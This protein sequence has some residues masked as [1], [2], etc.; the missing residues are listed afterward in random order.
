MDIIKFI[1]EGT[2]VPNPNYKK[3]AKKGLSA[4]PRLHS[5]N[6]EDVKDPTDA[7]ARV[8]SEQTYGLTYLRDEANKFSKNRAYIN[9][10]SSQEELEYERA[11]NQPLMTQFGHMLGQ[12][13]GNEI[14]LGTVRGFSD[15]FD[16]AVNA[17]SDENDYTN[18]VSRTI[19]DWQSYVRDELLPIYQKQNDE[20]FH[21]ND[22]GW[23]MNGL[24]SAATTVSLMVPGMAVSKGAGLIGKIG[25]IGGK[26]GKL[27]RKGVRVLSKGKNTGRIY[28]SL[29]G[30][31]KIGTMAFVSRTAENYQEAREVYKN[32]YN[33]SLSELASMSSEERNDLYSRNPEF[34]GLSD[35]EIAE[36][37]ASVSSGHTFRNDYWMLLM[38]IP[39]FKALSSIWKGA[40]VASKATTR[41]L[42][43]ANRE[44]IARLTGKSAAEVAAEETAKRTAKGSIL[45]RIGQVLKDLCSVKVLKKV[46]K[47]FKLKK[48]KKLVIFILILN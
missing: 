34:Q 37:I 10:I 46:S 20:G 12:A 1:K 5:D 38:D 48:E 33:K 15:L 28:H 17:F 3:G 8:I 11:K 21:I 22:F 27:A 44:Q 14:I 47:V 23:W 26:A 32:V 41:A 35:N 40:G 9:P 19:E 6:I 4:I 2:T 16:A 30:G 36:Q 29:K 43:K 7:T 39:Q 31:A 24:T 18:P 25:N 42:R 13:L 45:E